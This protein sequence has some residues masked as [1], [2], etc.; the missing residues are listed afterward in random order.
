[1]KKQS[2]KMKQPQQSL[3]FGVMVIPTGSIKSWSGWKWLSQ[4]TNAGGSEWEG[5]LSASCVPL[6]TFFKKLEVSHKL[7]LDCQELVLQ[8]P[9]KSKEIA[10]WVAGRP[11]W[12][13]QRSLEK[14]ERSWRNILNYRMSQ[15]LE[16]APRRDSWRVNKFELFSLGCL[17]LWDVSWN[18]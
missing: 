6:Y 8:T 13:M 14:D 2:R 7:V 16:S 11:G 3:R 5:C 4:E 15:S 12:S 9:R 18:Y 17:F 10:R 1:M